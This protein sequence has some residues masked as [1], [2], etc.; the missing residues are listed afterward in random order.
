MGLPGLRARVDAAGGHFAAG[1]TEDGWLVEASLPIIPEA[2][3]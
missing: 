1:P 2:G 3:R